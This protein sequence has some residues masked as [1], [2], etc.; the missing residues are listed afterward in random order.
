MAQ[1][2]SLVSSFD[3]LFVLCKFCG[4]YPQSLKAFRK[5][6]IFQPS[7]WGT[8][9]VI[10]YMIII[11][12]LYNFL[13]YSFHD[14]DQTTKAKQ[15]TLTF[16]IG[17]FLNYI[18]PAMLVVD[19]ISAITNQ[20][21]IGN[22]FDRI[23]SVDEKLSFENIHINNVS[24]KKR[25]SIMI[26]IA[27]FAEL[28]IMISTFVYLVDYTQWYS[29]LWIMSCI[30]TLL[31]VFDKIWFATLLFCLKQRFNAINNYLDDLV[32]NH[33]KIQRLNESKMESETVDSQVHASIM[34]MHSGNPFRVSEKKRIFSNSNRVAVSNSG[35]SFRY[36]KS[37]KIKM[38]NSVN[39][40]SELSNISKMDDK[41]SNFCQLHDEIC[42]LGKWLNELWSYP[43]LV[44]MAYGFLIFTAQLY[45]LY[46]GT[47]GQPIPSLFRSA[48]NALITSIY[49]LYTS[50]KCIYLIYLSWKTSLESKRTGICLH[51]CGV[52]VD[53]NA[54]YE[55]VNHLSLKLLN[56]SVDFSACGFFT[57]DMETLYGV[58]GGITS[59]L[60]ILIQFNLAAQQAKESVTT[61]ANYNNETTTMMTVEGMQNSTEHEFAKLIS[62]VLSKNLVSMKTT[63]NPF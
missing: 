28:T 25:I 58:S 53:N 13:I 42:E 59:Y 11:L 37:N 14:E 35:N 43:V 8:I 4:I 36:N 50:G 51:K 56:H 7:K 26:I 12:V 5:E 10:N 52:A 61:N 63:E 57:L 15:S 23:K 18:A 27:V 38:E 9:I 44:L 55:I 16:V 46:C 32:E 34:D 39:V 33:Y 48:K 20:G 3:V 60:I 30:P 6:K 2:E 45:F 1:P 49:L 22:F 17:L 54:F 21:K 40:S 62:N 29:F 47:Q 24:I 31:S 41:L 19:Q